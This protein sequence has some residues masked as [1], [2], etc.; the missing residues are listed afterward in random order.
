MPRVTAS[1][2]ISK[3]IQIPANIYRRI[4]GKNAWDRC[5]C[6]AR[7]SDGKQRGANVIGEDPVRRCRIEHR[8]CQVFREVY[9]RVA[10]SPSAGAPGGGSSGIF[11]DRSTACGTPPRRFDTARNKDVYRTARTE[12]FSQSLGRKLTREGLRDRARK[13]R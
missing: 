9:F 3:C 7:I 11:S 2:P 8:E 1:S 5:A 4:Y 6:R 13:G 12:S 10:V